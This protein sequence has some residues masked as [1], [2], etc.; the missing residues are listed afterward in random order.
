MPFVLSPS[1]TSA[2]RWGILAPWPLRFDLAILAVSF[3]LLLVSL[4]A[5]VQ[6]AESMILRY[7]D[8]DS[9]NQN[10]EGA[11]ARVYARYSNSRPPLPPTPLQDVLTNTTPPVSENRTYEI[12][13][14]LP[15]LAAMA[16][17]VVNLAL[18]ST[19]TLAPAIAL[20]ECVVLC[21]CWL[22]TLVWWYFIESSRPISIAMLFGAALEV[23]L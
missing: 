17:A 14:I 3:P 12:Q 21:G 4:A 2:K 19:R 6:L 9:I 15:P 1:Q 22:C 8:V 16:V 13:T 23:L 20:S 11:Y 7:P 10:S 18:H 5:G